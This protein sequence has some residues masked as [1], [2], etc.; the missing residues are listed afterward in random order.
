MCN[1]TLADMIELKRFREREPDLQNLLYDLATFT[2]EKTYTSTDDDLAEM[3]AA[4]QA[5]RTVKP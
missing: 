2:T 3:K 1:A 4:A 5:L